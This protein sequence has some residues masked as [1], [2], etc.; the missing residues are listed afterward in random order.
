[1]CGIVA[2][3]GKNIEK[4]LIEGLYR[5]EY[6]GYDSAGLT[7]FEGEQEHTQKALGNVGQLD[8]LVKD[9]HDGVGIAHTRWATHGNISL[10]NAHPHFSQKRNLALVHNGIIENYLELKEK[11][12]GKNYDFYG[13][14]D[15]EVVA[16]F[17]GEEIDEKV[18]YEKLECIKGSYAFAIICKGQERIYFVKNKSP[19]YILKNGMIASDPSCFVG[20]GEEYISLE[21]G[22][23]GYV[24]NKGVNVF[25][26]GQRIKKIYKKIDFQFVENKKHNFKHFMLKEI[27][28]TKSV[29][30]GI[31]DYYMQQKTK[32][33]VKEIQIENFENVYFIACGTAYHA[34]LIA[35]ENFRRVFDKSIFIEKA[36]EF[37]Y[38]N[39]KLNEKSLCFFISQSGETA[40]T[41][42]A[43]EF[44]KN[45]GAKCV[46]IVNTIYSTLSQKCDLSF[47]I[48]AGQ[49]RAV[50]ST[51]AYFGQVLTLSVIAKILKDEEFEDK[52]K[53]YLD[54]IDFGNDKQILQVASYLQDKEKLFFVGRGEDYI[55]AL[56]ASLKMKE[57]S[58][59]FSFGESSAELKHGSLALIEKGVDAVMIATDETTLAKNMGSCEEIHARGGKIVLVSPF[60]PQGK[61]DFHL[62][63]KPCNKEFLSLQAMIILQKLA[64][65][66]AVKR[67][68]NPD[69]PR[70]LAKSV[71]VE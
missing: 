39:Y 58:Y 46:A 40:D 24:D 61:Y 69:K 49:E 3:I 13:Q 12:K 27:Y 63:V 47:P 45:K 34:G 26:K 48:C 7:V 33:K 56:E 70:N 14:S 37:C 18:L 2:C 59:I 44:A 67:G 51:K 4:K 31:R 66:T 52:L 6:R 32:A 35:G 10:E 36:G 62:F 17:L 65:F 43:F 29:L 41:L 23:Y 11:L 71:T 16:K 19:L 50:A 21:D 25:K 28:D 53:E 9:C 68:N 15:S 5:L 1:M 8:K 55:S 57:I 42:S 22:E 30:N 20:Y 60:E 38:K 64:Y 54:E